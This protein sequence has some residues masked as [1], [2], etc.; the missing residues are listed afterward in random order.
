LASGLQEHVA[1][2]CPSFHPEDQSP[3]VL[4][5]RAALNAFIPQSLLIP[6]FAWTQMQDVAL[7]F[8]EPHEVHIGQPLKPVQVPLDGIP[9]LQ[10]I[11]Q[12][13]SRNFLKQSDTIRKQ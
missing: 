6:G 1:G 11:G 9:S 2:S 12:V 5:G 4:P 13:S 7:G 8:V 10:P 3:Q